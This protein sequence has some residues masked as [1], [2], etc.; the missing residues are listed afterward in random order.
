MKLIKA[1]EIAYFR[2][3]Y[4]E[5]ISGLEDLTIIFG[6]NDA[7]K[8]NILRA[9]NLFFNQQTNPNHDFSFWVDLNQKRRS[10]ADSEGKRKFIYVKI[11]F[12]TPQN[13]QASLGREFSIKRQWNISS[14]LEYHQEISK[15]VPQKNYQLSQLIGINKL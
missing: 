4:K 7:G 6:R 3:F 10:E 15:E 14:G 9:L 1:I 13:Y 8:S 5:K 11:T 12:N 2:S